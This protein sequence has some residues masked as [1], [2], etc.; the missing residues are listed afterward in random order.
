MTIR[1]A[2]ED[3]RAY[4]LKALRRGGLAGRLT[5]GYHGHPRLLREIAR[6]EEAVRRGVPTPPVGFGA[7]ARLAGG[8]TASVLATLEIEGAVNLASLLMSAGSLRRPGRVPARA[9]NISLARAG[10]A[11]RHAHD[12]GLDHGDLNIGNIILAPP[13][14]PVK[15]RAFAIGAAAPVSAEEIAAYVVDVGLSA[16]RERLGIGRRANGVV[17][18]LRSAEKHLGGDPRRGRD[19][20]A[21][22]H[23]YCSVGGAE[24]RAFRRKFLRAVRRRLPLIRIHQ[25]GW[26][27]VAYFREEERPGSARG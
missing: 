21:F 18:L 14:R 2:G 23:G 13:R 15:M 17:R 3:G 19:I 8:R 9:R 24:A 6:I 10:R 12:L 5:G 27:I 11:V 26:A 22:I 4:I 20:A 25:A 16:L 1:V 7:S